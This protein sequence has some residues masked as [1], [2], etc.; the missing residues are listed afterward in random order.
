MEICNEIWWT[1]TVYFIYYLKQI[2]TINYLWFIRLEELL[3]NNIEISSVYF[4]DCKYNEKTKYFP[5]LKTLALN[6]NQINDVTI[7]K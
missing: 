4:D 3:A 1:K 5:N 2:N 6:E 7:L